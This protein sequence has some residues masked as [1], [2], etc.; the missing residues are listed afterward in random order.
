MQ[1]PTLCDKIS[2]YHAL[3][4]LMLL[5]GSCDSNC[6]YAADSTAH[7]DR[8]GN[9]YTTI[10]KTSESAYARNIWDMQVY[11]A[12]LF[13]GAGNSS[14]QGPAQN[15]GP[16][17]IVRFDPKTQ[18]FTV[19]GRVDE[20]QID[21]FK[22]IDGSLYIP[23]HDPT[24]SWDWG[25]VY[26]R[27]SNGAWSKFRRLP[28][29]LHV[30]DLAW[31]DKTLFGAVSVRQGAAVAISKDRGLT[32]TIEPIGRFRT[33]TLLEIAD[34][35]YAVKPFVPL[36][37]G[38][39]S[40]LKEAGE[41]SSVYEF[42]APEKF[43]R[44]PD[45]S[46]YALFP[47]TFLAPQQIV[48]ITRPLHNHGIA[49]YIGAYQH[50]DHQSLPFGVYAASSLYPGRLQVK[51]LP[52]P[53]GHRPWDLLLNDDYLYA[54]TAQRTQEQF[55]IAVLRV[56]LGRLDDWREVLHF[57]EKTFARSFEMLD[58]DFY[59]GLGCEVEDPAHWRQNELEGGCGE[60]LRIRSRW[61][62]K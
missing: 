29:V 41:V 13:L 61:Y 18:F 56:P 57:N 31:H 26:R 11:G 3:V 9:P 59:F 8:L 49:F 43:L 36:T 30:Y 48:K 7:V 53:S 6:L 25:N 54:L 24:E 34:R 58:G 33:Y 50:N 55:T 21:A 10:Y 51:K 15:A 47:D 12:A 14:N 35:L 4:C 5:L 28:G 19:E 62:K 37:V 52:L 16:V 40:P 45:L 17:P 46:K 42:A 60:M 2:G 23:G 22:L 38:K 27:E 1:N 20:E 39:K 32:W 44:R